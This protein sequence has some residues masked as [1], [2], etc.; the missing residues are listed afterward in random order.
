MDLSARDP[1]DIHFIGRVQRDPPATVIQ[2]GKVIVVTLSLTDVCRRGSILSR[3]TVYCA[4]F[5]KPCVSG[6]SGVGRATFR[7]DTGGISEES[8]FAVVEIWSHFPSDPQQGEQT[9]GQL[10]CCAPVE[11]NITD[12]HILQCY[13]YIMTV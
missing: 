13:L 2:S 9:E 10:P 5:S 6:S 3:D 12:E 1:F 11:K 8:I 4:E 7:P